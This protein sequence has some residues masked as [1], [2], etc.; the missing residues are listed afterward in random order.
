MRALFYLSL[1]DHRLL[2]TLHMEQGR[3]MSCLH[4]RLMPLFYAAV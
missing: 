4:V 3:K 2:F 1:D